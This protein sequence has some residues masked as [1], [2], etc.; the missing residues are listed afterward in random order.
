MSETQL[1]EW[2]DFVTPFIEKNTK[3][4][5]F[6]SQS[7]SIYSGFFFL[8]W[9]YRLSAGRWLSWNPIENLC[10]LSYWRSPFFDRYWACPEVWTELLTLMGKYQ[11]TVTY[12]RKLNVFPLAKLQSDVISIGKFSMKLVSVFELLK[13]V[14]R[15]STVGGKNKPS[16][17][18]S[19]L[20]LQNIFPPLFLTFGELLH[21][22]RL[23]R[24]QCFRIFFFDKIPCKAIALFTITVFSSIL[25]EHTP[26]LIEL[27]HSYY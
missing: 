10:S 1:N 4:H 8:F 20:R 6:C 9:R 12:R 17:L 27:A 5:F 22:L 23:S 26:S 16:K 3:K 19:I 25:L 18:A 14:K 21:F 13:E 7:Y 2:K 15:K 11:Y 24:R